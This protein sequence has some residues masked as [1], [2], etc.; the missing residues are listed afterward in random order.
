MKYQVL[1]NPPNQLRVMPEGG[2]LWWDNSEARTRFAQMI[3]DFI[4]SYGLKETRKLFEMIC[5][6]V[7]L[8]HFNKEVVNDIDKLLELDNLSSNPEFKEIYGLLV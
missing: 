4:S 5:T 2:G 1:F 6:S 7:A 3:E 8:E